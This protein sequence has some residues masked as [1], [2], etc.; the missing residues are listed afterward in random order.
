M[1]CGSELSLKNRMVYESTQWLCDKGGRIYHWNEVTGGK[2]GKKLQTK[3]DLKH[4]LCGGNNVI[5]SYRVIEIKAW[6]SPG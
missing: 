3:K 2:R 4:N 5:P 1:W 6:K